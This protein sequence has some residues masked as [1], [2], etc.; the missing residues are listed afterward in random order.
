[1]SEVDSHAKPL[2]I[3][4]P[5]ITGASKLIMLPQKD[6][7]S[8]G[9]QR[10]ARKE[11]WT[12]IYTHTHIYIYVGLHG[13]QFDFWLPFL[14]TIQLQVTKGSL[15]YLSSMYFSTSLVLGEVAAPFPQIEIWESRTET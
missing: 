11:N 10:K 2:A 15:G 13:L 1:M 5:G 14:S 4:S 12:C 7:G 8:A 6:G 3:R 9:M